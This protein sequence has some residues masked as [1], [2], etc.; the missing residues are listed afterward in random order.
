MNTATEMLGGSRFGGIPRRI[1][2]R[3]SPTTIWAGS[4]IVVATI[5]ATLWTSWAMSSSY[6]R[7]HPGNMTDFT[8]A[9]LNAGGQSR[10]GGLARLY[11]GDGSILVALPGFQ[12]FLVFLVRL[13]GFF[14]ASTP[15]D[16]LVILH[17]RV[18]YSAIGVVWPAMVSAAYS[19][20]FAT[21]I[22]V[23]A[24]ARRCALGGTRLALSLVAAVAA[25]WWMSVIWGHPDDAVA[26]GL[27]LTAVS[28]F[29]RQRD[30]GAAWLLGAGFAVQPLV[31]L[32]APLLF[33]LRPMRDWPRLLVRA[34]VPGALAV[35]IPLLGDPRD[36]WRQ[37]VDQPTYPGVGHPTPWVSVVAHPTAGVVYAGWPRALG[38]A[39]AV[40]AAASIARKTRRHGAVDPSEI[41]WMVAVCLFLRCVFESVIFPYY[42]VPS[43]LLSLVVS[44][45]RSPLRLMACVVASAVAAYTAT[46]RM[47]DP[48]LY[49]ALVVGCLGAAVMAGRPVE[50][51]DK[52]GEYADQGVLLVDEPRVAAG[53]EVAVPA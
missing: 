47:G 37:V 11:A 25:L 19:L 12:L 36:T 5:S 22:A 23:L 46:L 28:L 44:A 49:W 48:V 33:A 24:L 31:L 15:A 18:G 16:K 8:W 26:L 43:I 17:G 6:A 52:V 29:L 45:V 14:G 32:A 27:L 39:L 4:L 40:A 51:P 3:L 30:R 41:L 21:V 13:L 53:G 38:V 1:G 10:V 9:I 35:M 2:S 7:G 34:A 20:A 42:V 50:R